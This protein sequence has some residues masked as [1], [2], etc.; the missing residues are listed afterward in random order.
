MM[1]DNDEDRIIKTSRAKQIGQHIGI[2]G[3]YMLVFWMVLAFVIVTTNTAPIY[4]TLLPDVSLK[5]IG[6]S[7]I[8]ELWIHEVMRSAPML[9][10]G[11]GAVYGFLVALTSYS[12]FEF[13]GG[14]DTRETGLILALQPVL[15][16]N[17]LAN[18]ILIKY[19]IVTTRT[20]IGLRHVQPDM[21][22]DVLR[23]LVGPTLIVS[24]V[25]M[26]LLFASSILVYDS[27]GDQYSPAAMNLDFIYNDQG[28]EKMVE[29]FYV[30]FFQSGVLPEF[31]FDWDEI[32][33]ALI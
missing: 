28:I 24:V 23:D 1:Y 21:R 3:I 11:V 30:V 2:W 12:T 32:Q 19:S 5:V 15:A 29:L 7:G 16:L 6:A 14:F 17:V 20:L 33:E 27:T 8:L 25:A 9:I 22:L 26:G 18:V 13:L 10:P 4:I 31:E